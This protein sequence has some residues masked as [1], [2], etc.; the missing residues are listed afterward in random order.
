MRRISVNRHADAAK[1]L[2]HALLSRGTGAMTAL[3]DAL[4]RE[5]EET[6]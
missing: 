5:Q 4:G 1:D 2:S 3:M 6:P